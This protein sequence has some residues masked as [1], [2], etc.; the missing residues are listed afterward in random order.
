[1]VNPAPVSNNFWQSIDYPSQF[2]SLTAQDYAKLQ[3]FP[4]N[5]ILHP[6]SSIAKKQLGNAVSMPVVAVIIRSI[7]HCL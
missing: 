6:N 1:M 7:L 2:R 3:G 5:F 4:E